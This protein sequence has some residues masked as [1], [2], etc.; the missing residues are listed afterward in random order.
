MS[1]SYSLVL[2]ICFCM[3]LFFLFNFSVLASVSPPS[4]SYNLTLFVLLNRFITSFV[5][6]NTMLKLLLI[7]TLRFRFRLLGFQMCRA[8]LLAP[9]H[10]HETRK[11]GYFGAR[12][13]FPPHK[14]TESDRG[15]NFSPCGV[16]SYS[17]YSIHH[18]TTLGGTDF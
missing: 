9:P 2:S 11:E 6:S 7:L 17:T 16:S 8:I 15:G 14:Y 12:A 10:S 18:W 1:V 4:V 13:T 5:Y 3:F